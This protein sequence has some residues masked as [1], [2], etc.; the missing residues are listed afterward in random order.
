M[1]MTNAIKNSYF[2]AEADE[3]VD[4]KGSAKLTN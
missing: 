2:L 1:S 4:M 3:N